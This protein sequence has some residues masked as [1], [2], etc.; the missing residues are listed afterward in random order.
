M[1]CECAKGVDE[2]DNQIV[3][4]ERTSQLSASKQHPQ[5]SAVELD[6]EI[7]KSGRGSFTPA[8]ARSN[9][10]FVCDKPDGTVVEV[11]RAAGNNG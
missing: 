11:S 2:N 6:S 1:G 5:V 4:I 10:Y 3:N 8:S 7:A 9:V